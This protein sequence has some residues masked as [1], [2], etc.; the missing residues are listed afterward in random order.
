M[1][2]G[3]S[4]EE[5]GEIDQDED[6]DEGSSQSSSASEYKNKKSKSTTAAVKKRN[7]GRSRKESTDE[8]EETKEAK[9]FGLKFHVC[10]CSVDSVDFEFLFLTSFWQLFF[11]AALSD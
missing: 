6:S 1:Q 2:L 9:F 11:I 5:E 4:S 10:T 8:S 7:I 3:S